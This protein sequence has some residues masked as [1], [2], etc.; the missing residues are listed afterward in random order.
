MLLVFRASA[1]DESELSELSYFQ[2]F[3]FDVRVDTNRNHNY[4]QISIL[5]GLYVYF[6]VVSNNMTL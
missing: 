4:Q 1:I 6:V 3:I 2:K 5:P